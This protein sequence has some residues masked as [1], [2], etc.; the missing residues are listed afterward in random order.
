MSYKV[1]DYVESIPDKSDNPLKWA[2]KPHFPKP[3]PVE[4]VNTILSFLP[5][6]SLSH[7]SGVNKAWYLLAKPRLFSHVKLDSN[8]HI[9][10]AR[11]PTIDLNVGSRP[12]FRRVWMTKYCTHLTIGKHTRSSHL[13]GHFVP[14]PSPLPEDHIAPKPLELG[15]GCAMS[16]LPVLPDLETV[17]IPNDP[18]L[19][20]TAPQ[21]GENPCGFHILQGFRHLVVS[22]VST[23]LLSTVSTSFP[24][25]TARE[26]TL[27]VTP[28]WSHETEPNPVKTW[29]PLLRQ[30][31]R[32]GTVTYVHSSNSFTPDPALLHPPLTPNRDTTGGVPQGN[33]QYG[34][35]WDAVVLGFARCVRPHSPPV[36]FVGFEDLGIANEQ[37]SLQV[38]LNWSVHQMI[39]IYA[40]RIA[41]PIP[42]H[43][44]RL[45]GKS[46][47]DTCSAMSRSEWAA[48]PSGLA[49]LA[50]TENKALE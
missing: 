16:T 25:R 39:K 27:L 8:L 22:D 31:S 4:V 24:P 17:I 15:E 19:G 18:H 10:G 45:V 47:A 28:R 36:R 43:I 23:S 7:C 26:L 12:L 11:H 48:S 20:L 6:T 38:Y 50:A 9:V 49:A 33:R 1:S 32:D 21:A 5:R 46:K 40:K 30:L 14:H 42:S 37:A 2:T 3:V 29:F 35:F 34:P 41:D 44:L 13:C